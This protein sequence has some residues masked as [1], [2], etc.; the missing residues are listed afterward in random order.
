MTITTHT[1]EDHPPP[2]RRRYVRLI[3]IEAVGRV[4]RPTRVYTT[5]CGNRIVEIRCPY[6]DST[7]T[8]GWPSDSAS[9][10]GWR[11]PHCGARQP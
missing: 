5:R 8:H 7:H 6:C 4:A 3:P 9:A 10:P 11:R 2:A 1:P